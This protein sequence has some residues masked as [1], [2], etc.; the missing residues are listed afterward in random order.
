MG[1]SDRDDAE[2]A[3]LGLLPDRSLYEMRVPLPIAERPRLPAGI[4]V[5]TFQPG[6]DEDAWL[7]VNNRAF[8][9]HAEQGGWIRETLVRREQDAWF[10]PSLFFLGFDAEGLA[11][12]NWLKIH[13]AHGRDPKLGEI[14]VIGVDPRTQGTGLGR[15]LAIIGLDAVHARGIDTG[16]LFTAAENNEGVL[17][18]YRALGFTVH[19]TDRAYEVEVPEQ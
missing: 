16:S 2:L 5:R 1:A 15:A 8:Q 14:F 9:N 7:T 18:L 19:R 12:F 4:E 13:D 3:R 17:H 6:R 11:G 10:D